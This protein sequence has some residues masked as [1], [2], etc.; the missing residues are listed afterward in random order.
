MENKGFTHLHLHTEYSMLD[1]LIKIKELMSQV[2]ELGM[3]AV[4]ITDH[5]V[6]HGVVDFYKAAKDAEIKPIIGVE[7][8]ITKDH[9]KKEGRPAKGDDEKAYFHLTLL[10]KNLQGYKNLL[11]LVSIAN[12][13]GYYYKPRIDREL[14]TQYKEGL[15]VL[16]G[17]YGSEF[18]HTLR[19]NK[20]DPALAVKRGLEH[21]AEYTDLFGDDY[22]IEIQRGTAGEE[23]KVLEP[24]LRE[25]AKQAN[26]KLIATGDV[27]Y[28]YKE[29]AKIQDIYWAINEGLTITDP[30]HKPMYTE[31]LYLKSPDEFYKLFNDIPEAV[32]NTNEIKEK[33]EKYNIFFDRVQPHYL[34]VPEGMT[35][36]D[37][38]RDLAFAGAMKRY[39]D[40]TEKTKERLNYELSVIHDKGY[41][42]YFLIVADYIRWAKEQ[43]II[44]G[45]GR[46]SGAGS[47]VAYVLGITDIDPFWWGLQFERFLNPYRPSPP[48]FDIDFQDDRR[49]EVISYIEQKYGKENVTAI[50][51][52]GRLEA[53]A[54]IRDVSRALGIPLDLVD[55][56]AKMI[57]VKRGKPMDLGEAVETISE[58]SDF[59]NTH[60]EFQNVIKAV[61]RIKK[62]ARHVSV[63]AC[64]Y[65]ITP[66]PVSDYVPLRRA[67]QDEDLV[68]TQI[69]GSKI[70]DVGLMKYD[71]L[72]LRTLT[73][74][75]N[76]EN[77]IKEQHGIETDW[78][79]IGLDDA[80]TYK[81][82]QKGLTDSVFQ[83]E[84]GG[85]KKFLID[86]H[87]ERIEDINFMAAA[88]RPGPMGYIPSYIDR[89]FG[90]EKVKYLH[91]D[92][93]PILEETM[94]YAV[95]QEQVMQI[96]VDLGGYTV[97]Q[98]DLLRRAMGK[99][100]KQILEGEK[101]KLIE[102]M[103]AR[104]YNREL[105]EEVF[106]YMLPFA[107]YGFNKAHSAC[108]AVIAYRTAYLKA[109]HPVEFVLG[110][111]QSDLERIPKLEKD[112]QMALSMHIKVL[113]PSINKSNMKFT[114][115]KHDDFMEEHWLDDDF[116]KILAEKEEK[117]EYHHLGTILYG[118]G[119]IKGTSK[120]SLEAILEERNKNGAFK[121]LDDL[122][123]RVNIEQVDKKTLLLLAQSGAFEEF[124][125]RNSLIALI[126]VLYDRYKSDKKKESAEQISLFAAT[127]SSQQFVQQTP[128]PQV[129]PATV[130]QILN[131]EKEMFGV[132]LTDHPLAQIGDYFMNQGALSIKQ[133]KEELPTEQILVGAQIQR[134]KKLNTKNGDLMA[135]VDLEDS[136][137]TVSGVLF[138]KVYEAFA[139]LLN[140]SNATVGMPFLFKG[141]IDHKLDKFSFIINDFEVIDFE[142]A[143]SGNNAIEH[144]V[145]KLKKTLKKE[146]LDSLKVFLKAHE[147]KTKLSFDV[148]TGNNYRRVA[149]RSGLFYTFDS[150]KTLSKYGEVLE[151]K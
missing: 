29:D 32:F 143:K 49:D 1:G 18:V 98:A 135:F 48:D 148:P 38:I 108:Y 42:D 149:Y 26:K 88:Y 33:V 44:V 75:K 57:P 72:G 53:K 58:V 126:P 130:L 73:I 109:H 93:K 47:V 131:W 123:S 27:H 128:L 140:E 5:G 62:G 100:D 92:L 14:L 63:H 6:M 146:D 144:V 74:L 137:D 67:P 91:E 51:A 8:Y 25:V 82:F 60:P 102:G 56:F 30:K 103:L 141:K 69:P 122:L 110:V 66:T 136:T 120:K 106:S 134:M 76:A 115:E 61:S 65:I 95:Y 17:C 71:F 37:H 127:T 94:G 86:L 139:K 34:D 85:M 41:D 43:G 22:Y 70:E 3:D 59:V 52:I 77:A 55:K 39:G 68:I 12:T 145:L 99:K 111:M 20:T 96:A 142:R 133:A 84:S 150:K 87:P 81:I 121:H 117:G 10:A 80:K 125:E 13:S 50:C 2:K 124:G 83:F 16:S 24:L 4:G 132:Y 36:G 112:L 23:E 64:G 116:D 46:G 45:P 19:L 89:K 119:G 107:D 101:E 28:M 79:E 31:E 21:V 129:E 40:I 151:G 54:A 9:L 147:G 11:K 35:A 90:R 104:G 114:I 138:P 118:L 105:G 15:I 113:P 7:A 78:N 97:G